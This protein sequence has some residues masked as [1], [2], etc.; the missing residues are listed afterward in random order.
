MWNEG[1]GRV[2]ESLA[3]QSSLDAAKQPY[4]QRVAGSTDRLRMVFPDTT[5]WGVG[6]LKVYFNIECL[7]IL[8]GW[9]TRLLTAVGDTVDPDG[10]DVELLLS[11]AAGAKFEPPLPS[12]NLYPLTPHKKNMPWS[13]KC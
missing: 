12:M 11:P 10:L 4:V 7:A 1:L 3:A 6:K 5:D 8:A 9:P 13:W 2:W